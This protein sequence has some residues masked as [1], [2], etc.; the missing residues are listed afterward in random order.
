VSLR[1]VDSEGTIAGVTFKMPDL[2][3]SWLFTDT[4]AGAIHRVTELNQISSEI[5]DSGLAFFGSND[6]SVTLACGMTA[7]PA[8]FEC[9]L[10]IDGEVIGSA[11]SDDVGHNQIRATAFLGIRLN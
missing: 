10:S 1:F 7:A 4:D 9:Q 11:S 6:R 5:S 2:S 3:G 8:R